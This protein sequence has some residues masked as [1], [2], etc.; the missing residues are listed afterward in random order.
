MLNVTFKKIESRLEQAEGL[1]PENR[2]ELK[3]LLSTLQTEVSELA[4]SHPEQSESI[5]GFVDVST[6]EATRPTQQSHLLKPALDGLSGTVVG[7][8]EEHP[9]ITEAI[10]RICV[11]LSN[12]G[13]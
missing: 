9:Q 2:E 1:A 8:E 6:H 11:L 7:F 4:K 5:T 10:N 13:I 3:R 12:M